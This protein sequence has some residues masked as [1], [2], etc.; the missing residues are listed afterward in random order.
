MSYTKLLFDTPEVRPLCA[1]AWACVGRLFPLKSS[2]LTN[3]IANHTH[4]R[5]HLRSHQKASLSQVFQSTGCTNK[6]LGRGLVRAVVS[7]TR[8]RAG[9][10]LFC[11]RHAGL[12]TSRRSICPPLRRRKPLK[13]LPKG[14]P[15]ESSPLSLI[16]WNY[17][18][19]FIVLLPR[20]PPPSPGRDRQ[21]QQ[22][23]VQT[24]VV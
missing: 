7:H 12:G 15:E 18:L 1:S 2:C 6:R 10:D 20:L 14:C 16:Y 11:Q 9:T 3:C 4:S 8:V 13:A 19:G 22:F 17:S 24:A 5:R 21:E 23:V